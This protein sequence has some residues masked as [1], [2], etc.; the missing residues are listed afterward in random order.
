MRREWLSCGCF[1]FVDEAAE[2]FVFANVSG[3]A[4]A[5]GCREFL[6]MQCPQ[7]QTKRD[8]A[9]R[10]ES[11]MAFARIAVFPGGTQE[12]YEHTWQP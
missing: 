8:Q 4:P 12:Q 3:E 10:E 5:S 11:S 6:L 1:V 7:G 2:Q 9:S